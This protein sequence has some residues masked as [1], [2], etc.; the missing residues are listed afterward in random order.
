MYNEMHPFLNGVL[1]H[2]TGLEEWCHPSGFSGKI[3]H[4]APGEL[5]TE[6]VNVSFEAS[7]SPYY[8]LGDGRL[9]RFSLAIPGHTLFPAQKT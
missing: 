9:L 6:I 3:D 8:N 1:L 7:A 5:A 4:G 2:L